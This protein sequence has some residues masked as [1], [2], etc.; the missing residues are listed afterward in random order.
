M[1]VGSESRQVAGIFGT[2]DKQNVGFRLGQRLLGFV[3]A[4]G[5]HSVEINPVFP[6]NAYHSFSHKNSFSLIYL[7]G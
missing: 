4:L 6:V 3:Q 5:S 1:H 7:F 2:E